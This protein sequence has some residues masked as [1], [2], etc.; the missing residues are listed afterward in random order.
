[1]SVT[2]EERVAAVERSLKRWKVL[3]FVLGVGL[4]GLG[5]AQVGENSTFD[6]V[7]AKTF[8]VIDDNGK[9]YGVFSSDT[10]KANANNRYGVVILESDDGSRGLLSPGA[11]YA[12]SPPK[13]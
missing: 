2:L 13:K 5:A 11:T 10:D 3:A 9:P 1:M 12:T 7:R 6:V 4:A 8:A